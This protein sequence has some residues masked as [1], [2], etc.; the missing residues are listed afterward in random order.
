MI[1]PSVLEDL[2]SMADSDGDGLITELIEIYL[3]DTPVIIEEIKNALNSGN[4]AKLK[5][6]AHAL[7]SPSVS[8]G[9]VNLGKICEILEYTAQSQTLEQ[10][11]VLVNQLEN[12]YHNVI[13]TLASIQLDH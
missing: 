11:T 10:I 1:D 13:M 4:L 5:K 9:A 6:S 7:R 3:E 12:E 2:R 8:I